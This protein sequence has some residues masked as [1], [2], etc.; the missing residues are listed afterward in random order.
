MKKNLSYILASFFILISFSLNSCSIEGEGPMGPPG[1]KGEDGWSDIKIITF[2]IYPNYWLR[3]N[4]ELNYWY[5]DYPTSLVNYYVVDNGTV[6]CYYGYYDRDG[7]V[8]K[9]YS[10]PF[11]NV[12]FDEA[13]G[14]YF[15]KIYDVNYSPGHI[16]IEIRDLNPTRFDYPD[17]KDVAIK[18][19]ILEGDKYNMLLDSGIDTK[20]FNAVQ[21]FF[22]INSESIIK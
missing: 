21:K 10:I 2:T 12:Y 18:A 16:E 11:T 22:N 20:D 13:L 7:Y 8:N 14:Q 4:S 17:D 19:V 6:L 3:D 9:W 1:P 5:Y 15:Q